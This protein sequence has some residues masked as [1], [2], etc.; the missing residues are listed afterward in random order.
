MNIRLAGDQ[1]PNQDFDE[2]LSLTTILRFRATII[3]HRKTYWN[4]EEPKP[5]RRNDEALF[6]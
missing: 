6:V 3:R 2:N 1:S 5:H 4:E